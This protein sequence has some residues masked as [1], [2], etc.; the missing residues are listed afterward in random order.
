MKPP[1]ATAFPQGLPPLEQLSLSLMFER[2]CARFSLPTLQTAKQTFIS[3]FHTFVEEYSKANSRTCGDLRFVLT[4]PKRR[5]LI[6]GHLRV[7]TP[8]GTTLTPHPPYVPDVVPCLLFF[9]VPPG[10]KNHRREVV[11]WCGGTKSGFAE[12]AGGRRSSGAPQV[13]YRETKK[14]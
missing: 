10:E 5:P 14:L 3:K 11:S 4:P 13:I 8:Q 6:S 2:L 1:C 9:F 12:S 7:R